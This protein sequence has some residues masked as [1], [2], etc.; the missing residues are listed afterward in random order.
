MPLEYKYIIQSGSG[1]LLNLES[2]KMIANDS[3]PIDAALLAKRYD[4]R[5]TA[6][7]DCETLRAQGLEAEIVGLQIGKLT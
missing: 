2:G 7:A 5:A 4:D 1:F 6:E 3:N